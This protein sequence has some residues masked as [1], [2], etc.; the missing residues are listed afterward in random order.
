MC[1]K[2]TDVSVLA[3]GNFDGVHLGHQRVLQEACQ[4]DV[5][6]L[7]VLTFWPHPVGVL[8]PDK[9]PKLL[10]DLRE[11][12]AKLRTF[13][14]N[15]VRVVRFN[16]AVA[17]MSPEEFV[18]DF[19]VGLQP[20]RIVVGSNFR[21]GA[22]AAGDVDTLRELAR[23]RFEVTAVP[24]T[25]DGAQTISSTLIRGNLHDGDVR[26]AAAHLGSPFEYRGL[27]VVG[28]RR[29]RD[30]GFPTANLVVPDEMAVPAD[31]V[32]AGWLT[33]VD[34]PGCEPLPAAISVGSNPTFDG[35]EHR[36]ESYVLDRTDLNLYGVEVQVTFIERLRGQQRF[37]GVDAL[38][39]QMHEDVE[40]AREI[41]R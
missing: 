41:L 4:G 2:V 33:R 15:E 8:R 19:L 16:Q 32:Y 3:I 27:V 6:R 11:R 37:D 7:I 30:L 22:K 34:I 39:A 12:I 28:D 40:H 9:A 36:V 14:A 29:G 26:A 25:T 24:L 5:G 10:M 17:A 35:T 38:I 31:G 1:N 21:F 13:G 23:G 20:T 18:E